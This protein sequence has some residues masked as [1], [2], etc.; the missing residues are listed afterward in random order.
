MQAR[1]I[2]ALFTITG[3]DE[4]TVIINRNWEQH[5]ADEYTQTDD[6]RSPV[7]LNC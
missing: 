7:L 5:L 1:A 2:N 4:W 3:K 6:D